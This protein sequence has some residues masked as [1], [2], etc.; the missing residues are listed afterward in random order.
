MAKSGQ[1]PVSWDADRHRGVG[2]G[3]PRMPA[4]VREQSAR[5]D[6]EAAKGGQRLRSL[7]DPLPA[8]VRGAGWSHIHVLAA[9]GL[10]RSGHQQGFDQALAVDKAAVAGL[11]AE[12]G[13]GDWDYSAPTH[14]ENELLLAEVN[15]LT[16]Q[17]SRCSAKYHSV[18]ASDDLRRSEIRAEQTALAAARMQIP[19]K[20]KL[21][22]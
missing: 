3:V 10:G 2:H 12:F 1:S 8:T 13:K 14:T 18:L 7:L 11:A 4:V 22:E 15:R 16:L 6:A 19:L 17:A 5:L 21:G 20:T 9:V